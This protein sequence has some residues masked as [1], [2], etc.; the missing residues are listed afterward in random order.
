[1]VLR[2]RWVVVLILALMASGCLKRQGPP[3]LAPEG[4]VVAVAYIRDDAQRRGTVAQ[5][6]E[7]VRQRVLEALAKRNLQVQEV[8]YERYATD[9]AKVTDSQRRFAMLK[10][11]APEAP[12]LLLVE[13]RV[14]FFGQV[15][16]RFSW[17]VYVKTTANRAT[18]TLEPTSDLQDYGAALQ[19]DQQREDDA[20]N[21][22]SRQISGQAAALF[23]SFLASPMLVPNTEGGPGVVPGLDA[24]A[25]EGI[26][27]GKSTP[28]ELP[29]PGPE[30]PPVPPPSPAPY[31]GLWTPPAGDAIYF[32]MVDRFSNGDAGND[33]TVDAKDAQ[34]FHGGDLRGVIDRLDGLKSLGV[35]TVWLSPVFQMRTEKFYGYGAFHGYWV[36][37]F[38]RVEPRFGDEALLTRLSDEL[39]RRDMR[40]V[41]DVVLNHV[42][43][44]TRLTREKP[45]W[46]HGLGPIDNWNDSR[47]LVMRDVHGLPDLAVEQEAVYAHLLS[48]S[49]K[50]V[51]AVKPAGFRLDAVKHLPMDFWARYNDD[52]R[53]H[54][55]NDFLL[56]GELLDGDPVLLSRVMKE[57]R[58]GTMFDFPLAFALVDVFCRGRSPAHLG[59]VLFNDRLNPA[60]DS[61]VTL[62]DNH[63]LPRVMSECG[64]DLEKVKRALAVQLTARGVP[65]L[66][67]GIEEGLTGAKEPENRGDMRFTPDHPLRAWIG[68]LLEARRGSEALQRGETLVLAA[69]EDLFAYARVTPDEAVFIGINSGTKPRDVFLPEALGEA[70]Q[71]VDPLTGSQGMLG[72]LAE[73]AYFH[74]TNPPG[75][76][77]LRRLKPR[78]PG[79]FAALARKA[80]AW[81]RGE[82]ERRTVVL[83]TGDASVRVVGGGPELG[84]WKAERSLRPEAGAVTL[85]LPV[86]GVFEYKLVRDDGPGKFSW[87]A[88]PN[89]LLYV[90]QSDESD[91]ASQEPLRVEVAWEQRPAAAA[92]W[93]LIRPILLRSRPEL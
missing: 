65:A 43:P 85:S 78:T 21:E 14:S 2:Q 38:G 66:T 48:K 45:E 81:S 23:D 30:A 49:L 51:D 76:V 12:L 1:M 19:F 63:D 55:G 50:W 92:P 15:G 68:R 11:Q 91:V 27:P 28:T 40:L 6:P 5:V 57:G 72:R 20:Q 41:L 22:V 9:F 44:E 32:V 79:G 53:A 87:E 46:F 34:A 4:T 37:D 93:S 36:E 80:R 84:G 35:R 58:F 42:G 47:E 26:E 89:R 64:G 74:V 8:P 52:L 54:A 33:G 77:T 29:P 90:P 67:Y 73:S 24:P 71:G 62:L 56:L 16:G 86:G 75:Q 3:V 60:P 7:G 13:T 17:D 10:A 25:G 83:A 70:G 61:L 18:S 88:G 39:R 31:R 69:R 59:A 82:G